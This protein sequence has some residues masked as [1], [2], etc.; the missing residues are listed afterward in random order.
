MVANLEGYNYLQI[1]DRGEAIAHAI[2]KANK[3]DVILIAGK[4]HEDYQIVGTEK[5][6]FDDRE[7]ARKA[8]SKRRKKV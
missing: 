1:G 3:G 5:T 4:G 2:Q 8:L 7:E 6:H